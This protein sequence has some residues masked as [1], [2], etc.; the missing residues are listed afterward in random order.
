LFGNNFFKNSISLSDTE[1]V[2]LDIS[3][4]LDTIF[5]KFFFFIR[6]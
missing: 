2:K 4:K 1:P 3:G 6:N 5:K